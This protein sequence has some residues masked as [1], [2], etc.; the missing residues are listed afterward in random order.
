[1]K[2]LNDIL[3]GVAILNHSGAENP[4]VTGITSDSRLVTEGTVFVAVKGTQ[5]DGH[6]FVEG[7]LKAGASVIVFVDPNTEKLSSGFPEA[8][9]L[10]VASSAKALGIMACNWFG[11]PSRQM[12]LVAVTGT[13]GKTTTATLLH[14]LFG[15]LGY[16]VGL[17]ST[18]ENKIGEE[19]IPSTHTTPDPVSLNQLLAQMV[20]SG[21]THAF[22]EASS[23]AID[24]ERIAGLDFNG[25]IFSNI[26]HDHLDYHGTF[27][28]YIA[29]KKK[30]FDEL[31]ANA[32][33][34]VNADDRRGK[35][36]V[37]NTRSK[38]QTYSLQTMAPFRGRV[39][40]NTLQGLHMEM[41]G[42]EVWFRLVGDFNA[43]N[44][45]SVFG[46]AL[47]LGENEEQVLIALSGL[48]PVRGRFERL[49]LNN[50]GVAIVDYAHTPDA[51]VNVLETI[52]SMQT[53]GEQ[54]ITVVGCGGNRDKTKR[55]VMAQ[56]ASKLSTQVIL[57]SDN[58][59]NEEP[60][61]I[62]QEMLA[63]VPISARRK[64][65]IM[66]DRES[67]I[68]EA[69][70]M[71]QPTDVVLVAGKGHETY[72]EIKGVKHP[73]DDRQKILETQTPILK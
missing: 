65:A 44:L 31:P 4:V 12:N 11:N 61:Q 5:V 42:K 52:R 2:R 32:F 46:A 54:L 71:V 8:S 33:S 17:L 60:M 30:L 20:A 70:A 64:V 15:E 7:A 66:E 25:A 37:Q 38:I 69:V 58:P 47:L 55:P 22:M 13:N 57:T 59:R 68:R 3:E 18:V 10:H 24:Q 19:I 73:F 9:F 51:L 1:M 23:H 28:A 26:T 67:A 50:G 36:M 45:L 14:Q 16:K 6:Q 62:I 21:C 72:Q 53:P 63:G 35:V 40:S 48:S 27:D 41:N 43:Y 56:V 39:L 29:A 34:L 49:I